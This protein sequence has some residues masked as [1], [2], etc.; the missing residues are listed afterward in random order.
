[1][2][3]PH[4]GPVAPVS[5][6]RAIPRMA[7]GPVAQRKVTRQATAGSPRRLPREI[8]E[9]EIAAG[10]ALASNPCCSRLDFFQYFLCRPLLVLTA[11][12]ITAFG[13]ALAIAIGNPLPVLPALGWAVYNAWRYTRLARK[14]VVMGDV[15]PGIIIGKRPWRVAVYGDL[16][17]G[18]QGPRPAV[19]V[20][21]APLTWMPGGPPEIG[22]R[23]SAP[24]TYMSG[25]DPC[26]WTSFFPLP[27][28]T[29]TRDPAEAQAV[30]DSIDPSRW[31]PLEAWVRRN[32]NPGYGLYRL[33][34]G[35]KNVIVKPSRKARNL[36]LMWT[37][38]AVVAI[39]VGIKVADI[40]AAAR[41]EEMPPVAPSVRRVAPQAPSPQTGWSP[42]AQPDALKQMDDARQEA[43]K[44]QR[45]MAEQQRKL[46]QDLQNTRN[47]GPTQ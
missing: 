25:P 7:A 46:L 23:I 24:S 30:Q 37:A 28:E 17:T 32:P 19:K 21:M 33:W 6:P 47:G 35:T 31:A 40:R 18:F 11:V 9:R 26:A 5:R 39:V 22:K 42:A 43:A 8:L 38:H 16:T 15:N 1:M 3:V 10:K 45:E 20:L 2:A 34:P 14:L 12:N 41:S 44:A 36:T 29:L 27:M 13:V 4:A